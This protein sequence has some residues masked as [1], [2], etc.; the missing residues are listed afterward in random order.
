[1]NKNHTS[2]MKKFFWH[3]CLPLAIILM[4]LSACNQTPEGVTITG[5]IPDASNLQVFFDRVGVDQS[6]HILGRSD[7]NSNGE[8]S[9]PFPEGLNPGVY[10][11][12]IGAKKTNLIIDGSESVVRLDGDLSSFDSFTYTLSGSQSSTDLQYAMQQLVNRKWQ[13]SDIDNFVDTTRNGYLA[14]WVTYR[15]IG[16]NG[17]YLGTYKAALTK[18]EATNT[19]L[20]YMSGFKTYM[21]NVEASYNQRMAR[22]KIKVGAPAPEIKMTSPDGKEYALSDLKGNIVLI[23][24][25]A[26]WCGPC[27]RENPNVVKVYDRYKNE[28]F[29]IFSV[30]LDG[31]DGRIKA[32]LGNDAERIEKMMDQSK[33]KW[34]AAIQQDRLIWPYHVSDLK[35][36]DSSA[37]SLYGVTGIPK[38][39]MVDREGNIAYVGLRGAQSIEEALKS[40]L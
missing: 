35:R 21:G 37:A 31:V 30:S 20:E 1:M 24:F 12:R 27:R 23:D 6:S 9:I 39:F 40:L 38:T 28:G 15:S 36:W 22:E 33:N 8:Y 5:S 11:I 16:P 4:G 18:A 10:Q 25:W 14:T 17:Q 26:S 19:D 7:V 32:R 2:T 13:P 29:T 34:I 3:T